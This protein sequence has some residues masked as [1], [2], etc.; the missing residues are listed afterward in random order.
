MK[1]V[2]LQIDGHVQQGSVQ[3]IGETLWV[4]MAG[5]IFTYE[6]ERKNRKRGG[7]GLQSSGDILAP[8]PGKVTK[9]MVSDGQTISA[10]ETTLVLEAMKME[11]TLKAPAGGKVK[12]VKCKVGDQVS[13]G[14][15]L[16]QLEPQAPKV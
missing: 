2:A 13:L 10:Q 16:V 4:H 9:I 15:V 14:Q 7:A 6:P 5:Q 3:K 11:Y 12:I 8:M 1:K